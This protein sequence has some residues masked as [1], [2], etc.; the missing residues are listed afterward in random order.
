MKGTGASLRIII[1]LTSLFVMSC[2][3]L[4]A[5]NPVSDLDNDGYIDIVISNFNAGSYFA[6]SFIYWGGDGSQSNFPTMGATGNTVADLNAD[7]FQDIILLNCRT[8]DSVNLNSYIYWGD[9]DNSY[10]N[11]T[12]IATHGAIGV[13]VADLNYDGFIDIIV[14]NKTAGSTYSINSYIYWGDATYSYSTRKELPTL[15]AQANAVADLNRDGYLDIV[16]SNL[17]SG[18]YGNANYNV[19]SYI[20]WGDANNSYTNRT[21]LPTHGAIGN[22]IADLDNDGYP[23]IVFSNYYDGVSYYVNS[24]IYWGDAENPY[25]TKTELPTTGVQ[26]N[27]VADI[28][29]DGDLDI[30]FSCY[31]DG[32]TRNIRS[33]VFWGNNMRTFSS[34]TQLQTVGSVSNS[35]ADINHDGYMDILF[36]NSTDGTTNYVNS[37]IYW[38]D[39]VNPFSTRTEFATVGAHGVTVGSISAFGQNFLLDPEADEDGDNILNKDEIIYH[40]NPLKSDSDDDGFDDFIEIYYFSNP[41]D[42]NSIPH[43]DVYTCPSDLNQDGYPEI[44]ISSY[45]DGDFFT[46][47]YIYWGNNNTI[48]TD[49]TLLSS[50]GSTGTSVADLNSDGFAD[51]IIINQ[52]NAGNPNLNS[53][54]YWGSESNLYTT[55]TEFATHGAVGV[56]VADLDY[57]GQLDIVVSN[58]TDGAYA[59]NSYI[60]WGDTDHTYTAKTELPTLGAHANAIADLNNDGYLDIVFANRHSGTYGNADRNVNS[61]IYW[62]DQSHTYSSRTELETHGAIGVSIADLDNDNCLDIVFSNY[63]DNVNHEINSYIYWGDETNPY[64]TKTELPTV[65]GYGNTIAD[66]NDD[67][68]L[69]IIFA[70]LWDGDTSYLNSYIY[71]GAEDNAY[72]TR[73]ECPTVRAVGSSVADVN[74]DGYLDIIFA[75]SQSGINSYIYWGAEDNPYTT[76]SE[77][78]SIG[79]SGVTAGSESALGQSFILAP[80]GDY[81]LDGLTNGWETGYGLN[82]LLSNIGLDTDNDGLTDLQEKDYQ[83]NP[84]SDDSDNDFMPDGWEIENNLNPLFNDADL[85]LDNDGLQNIEEYGNETKADNPDTD[86]DSLDDLWEVLFGLNPHSNDANIDSDNDGLDN[87]GEYNAGTDPSD[88]DTDDDGYTDGEETIAGTDPLDDT[89]Y[90]HVVMLNA[91]T[92]SLDV[93]IIII[94]WASVPGKIYRVYVQSDTLGPDFVL[95]VDGVK[96]KSVFTYCIDQGAGPNDVPHP[97]DDPSGRMYKVTVVE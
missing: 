90:I 58:K 40:I 14:S 96:A 79:A 81:D 36:A 87:I 86:G 11:K 56:S 77:L 30:V 7:G 5:F 83:T 31:W 82:P 32:N 35:I 48:F 62:G 41:A 80:Y 75:N 94:G 27:S 70:S 24:Y 43:I 68:F 2:L 66:L 12:A 10:V 78:P 69:D 6:N 53:Y 50:I 21:E 72:S 22:S 63:F 85:D 20:Y 89:S 28:D 52:W 17:H 45:N 57:D 1:L 9:I 65:G 15:G 60:Y 38:G 39:A 95:L 44:I 33:L 88:P 76:R 42:S 37:Y 55:K 73:T 51:I 59:T 3:P 47:S 26:G 25:S 18:S 74:M 49:K 19:N 91:V 13:S 64:T 8:T 71:W 67:G 29:N 54:I 46:N 84:T 97:T 92:D 4:Y 93:P 61:Y 34:A 16:F 23:D